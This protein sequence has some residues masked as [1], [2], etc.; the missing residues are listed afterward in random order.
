MFW[1]IILFLLGLFILVKSA[2][3]TVKGASAVARFFNVSSWVI[4]LLIVGIGTSI[5][6]LSINISSVIKGGEVGIGAI[7]GSNTYNILFILGLSALFAPLT[8]KKEWVHRD[9]VINILAIL[10]AMIFGFLPVFGGAYAGITR[11]EGFVILILFCMWVWYMLTLS[12]NNIH[13]EE[14]QDTEKVALLTAFFLIVI[15]LAGVFLGAQWVVEGA[16]I[17]A[18]SLGVSE[19]IISVVIIGIGTSMPELVISIAAIRKKMGGIAI[20]NIIGSNI[21]DFIGIIGIASLFGSVS[22]PHDIAF[23]FSITLCASLMLLASMFLGTKYTLER[24][25]GILFVS[26]YLAY[27]CFVLFRVMFGW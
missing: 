27:L 16:Q 23:D 9:V 3:A 11:P 15:G 26:I 10:I 7:I 25:E 21:F 8:L 20:G 2:G 14:V 17:I 18:T 19:A 1:T 5:P 13:A 12:K 6:E 22:V 24:K 4:G